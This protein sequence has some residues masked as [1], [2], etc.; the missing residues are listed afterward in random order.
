M[1][2][3]F[4]LN[5]APRCVNG[6]MLCVSTV[7]GCV[8]RGMRCVST[9]PGCINGGMR[10][11]KYRIKVGLQKHNKRDRIMT[12]NCFLE[13]YC[14]TIKVNIYFH[15]LPSG[16]RNQLQLSLEVRILL[17]T[18]TFNSLPLF[19]ELVFNTHT[20]AEI[21]RRGSAFK[22]T[23]LRIDPVAKRGS[24]SR[25]SLPSQR[26]LLQRDTILQDQNMAEHKWLPHKFELR[27]LK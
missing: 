13:K 17:V 14:T 1:E 23:Y 24:G 8:N 21:H 7:P 11:V 15:T 18:D 20:I 10:C 19:S 4:A 12:G 3:C 16:H 6:G 2:V 9:V 25:F 27:M 22:T 5:T 26:R